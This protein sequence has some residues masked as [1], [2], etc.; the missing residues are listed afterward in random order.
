MY[1]YSVYNLDLVVGFVK[2]DCYC[3]FIVLFLLFVVIWCLFDVNL[4]FGIVKKFVVCKNIGINGGLNSNY[5]EVLYF[6][7]IGMFY[8]F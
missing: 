4:F 3:N 6:V 7:I 5:S 1:G 8:I 2:K